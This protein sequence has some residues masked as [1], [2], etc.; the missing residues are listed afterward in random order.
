MESIT[1]DRETKCAYF[2]N[3]FYDL[4]VGELNTH[5][6][7]FG[8]ETSQTTFYHQHVDPNL[9]CKII[10]YMKVLEPLVEM[11]RSN[12]FTLDMIAEGEL[13]IR[14]LTLFLKS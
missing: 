2:N 14:K 11:M 1:F 5:D 10:Y 13:V 12:Q 3:H 4:N 8:S 6:L 9:V 7:I